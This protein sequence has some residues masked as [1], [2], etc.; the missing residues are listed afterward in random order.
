MQLLDYINNIDF[1]NGIAKTLLICTLMTA[2]TLSSVILIGFVVEWLEMWQIKVLSKFFGNKAAFF[3]NNYVTYPGVI[4]HELAHAFFA[5][6]TGAKVTKIKLF[7]GF[8]SEQMGY[9]NF[10]LTG[11]KVQQKIQLALTCCAPVVIGLLVE[12]FLFNLVFKPELQTWS[13][14]VLWYCIISVGNHM[15][16]SPVDISNYKKGL[17]ALIPITFAIFWIVQYLVY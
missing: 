8:K 7:N 14:V 15:S 2:I 16:M 6:L 11:N 1:S 9:V 12:G 10:N 3:I 4:L 13:K 5:W 17:I